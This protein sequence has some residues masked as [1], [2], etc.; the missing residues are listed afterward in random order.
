MT[1]AT[2]EQAGPRRTF[3][4]VVLAGLASGTLVAVA[5]TRAAVS[6]E[7]DGQAAATVTA[8]TAA[9]DALT[10]PLVTSLALVTL[11]AWG[12]L[13]VTR[14]WV[15]RSA[16]V[17]A[18]LASGGALAA[19]VVARGSLADTVEESLAQVGATGGA[20]TTGWYVAALLGAVVLTC[21]AVL[22]VRLV[23]TWPEMGQRYENPATSGATPPEHVTDGSLDLWKAMDEGR[24][25]TD[26]GAP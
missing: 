4:P 26:R 24:D 6:V 22:A 15:R 5:G 12:V 16:A 13:L 9:G 21:A 14:S 19:A 17:L 2:S 18:L 10:M 23:P 7:A 1:E 8:G 25:P 20:G 3:G 11:A